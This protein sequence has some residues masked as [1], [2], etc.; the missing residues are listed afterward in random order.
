MSIPAIYRDP[1]SPLYNP[2]RNLAALNFTDLGDCNADSFNTTHERQECNLRLMKRQFAAA[3]NS[4]ELFFGKPYHDGSPP[5]PGGGILE[6][7][8]HS[9]VHLIAG[10]DMALLVISGL[11]PLFHVHHANID[12]LWAIWAAAQGGDGRKVR[13]RS[14]LPR[15]LL[16][17]L[18]REH[19]TGQDSGSRLH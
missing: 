12:R 3:S 16:P 18:G 13:L 9:S 14:G 1:S 11:D 8:P 7:A 17:L 10:Y 19:A 15:L 5:F 6:G 2:T 4:K